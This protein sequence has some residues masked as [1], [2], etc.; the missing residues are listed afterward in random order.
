MAI[1]SDDKKNKEMTETIISGISSTVA[2]SITKTMQPVFTELADIMREALLQGRTEQNKAAADMAESIRGMKVIMEQMTGAMQ[3]MQTVANSQ[4]DILARLAE[5]QRAQEQTQKSLTTECETAFSGVRDIQNKL[6]NLY[7]GIGNGA[8]ALVAREEGVVKNQAKVLDKAVADIEKLQEALTK[9]YGAVFE[10]LTKSVA[11]LNDFSKTLEGVSKE[12]SSSLTTYRHDMDQTLTTYREGLDRTLTT[13]RDGM[14]RSIS[15]YKQGIDETLKTYRDGIDNSMSSY[16]QGIDSSM[17][18]YKQGID[19]TL[20]TY[21]DG[22]DKTVETIRK[23]MD[24]ACE[25]LK[26]NIEGTVR[27]TFAVIDKELAQATET[28]GKTTEEVN[29]AAARLPKAIRGLA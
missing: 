29:E 21:R 10:E 22:T 2:D 15:T 28:L 1:W 26:T 14:D 16:K 20:S 18:S 6:S 11:T 7:D 25:K 13:Y 9:D 19:D 23:S 3:N 8:T 5:V 27:D 17:S 12:M 24:E 4:Q